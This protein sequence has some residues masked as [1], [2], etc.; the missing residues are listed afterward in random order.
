MCVRASLV[1]QL[2]PT[3]CDSMDCSQTGSSVHGILQARILVWLPLPFPGDP[4]DPG[5]KPESLMSPALAGRFV[6][7]SATWEAPRKYSINSYYY[8]SL[9]SKIKLMIRCAIIL[10]SGVEEALLH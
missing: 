7:P 1:A 8:Y 3:L 4:P 2:C 9:N 5:I 10:I 6:T